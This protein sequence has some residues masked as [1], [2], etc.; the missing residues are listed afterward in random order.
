MHDPHRVRL[1]DGFERLQDET[2]RLL[3]R[4]GPARLQELLEIDPFEELED[5]VGC[6]AR[7]TGNVEDANDVIVV[8]A[9]RRSRLVEEASHELGF[10]SELAQEHLHRH[11]LA[12]R[13][14]LSGVHR[15]HAPFADLLLDAVLPGDDLAGGEHGAR[16]FVAD[17]RQ[18]PHLAQAIEPIPV[19]QGGRRPRFV[20]HHEGTVASHATSPVASGRPESRP[21][22]AFSRLGCP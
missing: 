6:A 9:R 15:R 13:K 4:E 8:D 20:V 10:G 22:L 2:R 14:V 16:L 12:E 17:V 11:A 7:K 19:Q 18:A 5:D 1:G 3:D 21:Q